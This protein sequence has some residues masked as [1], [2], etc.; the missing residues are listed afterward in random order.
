MLIHI[1]K[2]GLHEL[3]GAIAP[4]ISCSIVSKILFFFFNRQYLRL[5]FGCIG[6][7]KYAPEA[8]DIGYDVIAGLLQTNW[9][10]T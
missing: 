4:N 1:A 9:S 10:D 6:P 8:T 7:A 3:K 5:L 2:L